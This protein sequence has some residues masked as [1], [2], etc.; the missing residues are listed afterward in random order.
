MPTPSVFLAIYLFGGLTFVPLLLGAILVHAYFTF[1]VIEAAS[2]N[3]TTG[4]FNSPPDV[5]KPSTSNS[6]LESLPDELKPRVHEPDVAAGYFAVCRE[7]VPGG[8]NGKPPE[9]TTAVGGI[10][11]AES[12]SVYQSMYRSIFDRNKTSTPTLD[13]TNGRKKA[14]NLFYVVLR[15]GHLMLYDDSEQL[16]VRHVVSLALYEVDIYSGGEIIPEGELWIKRNCIRLIPNNTAGHTE[17]S[18]KPFFFFSD[19]CSEKEDFYFAILQ[20]QERASS[21]SKIP[22]TPLHFD[23]A[24]LVKLV[25]Q[26]HASEEN[27]QTRWINALVGRLFLGLYKTAEME[28]LI[29]KKITKKIARV[30]KPAFIDDIKLQKIDMGDLPPFIT[31]PKLRELTVDGG[32]T[33]EANVKYKGNFRIDI[34]AVARIDLGPRFKARE[35][36]LVLATILRKLEGHIL[37]RIKPPPSNRLWISFESAPKMDISLE[38]I[39][40]SR[41]ITYGVIL[42]AIESRIRE[43]VNETLVLPFWDDM[44][45][46][47]TASQRFRGGIWADDIVDNTLNTAGTTVTEPTDCHSENVDLDGASAEAP[48]MSRTNSGEVSRRIGDSTPPMVPA[49]RPRAMR[50]SSFASVASP[51]VDMSSTSAE[52]VK[53]QSGAN[54]QDAAATMKSIS[55]SQ[56]ASPVESPVGSPTQASRFTSLESDSNTTS[57]F[58]SSNNGTG[59]DDPERLLARSASVWTTT[60]KSSN[61]PDTESRSSDLLSK[62]ISSPLP[63]L[64]SAEKRQ[65]LNHSLNSATAAAKKWFVSRQHHASSSPSTSESVDPEQHVVGSRHTVSGGIQGPK[66]FLGSGSPQIPLSSQI[67]SEAF[68]PPLGSPS[69]PIGR[70]QPLPPPGTPLPLPPKPEKR[71]SAWGAASASA[72]ANLTRRKPFTMKQSNRTESAST[73]ELT[74]S[75]TYQSN[76]SSLLNNEPIGSKDKL[77]TPTQRISSS[78]N[79]RPIPPLPLRRKRLSFTGTDDITRTEE[80]LLIVEAPLPDG[81]VPSSP[82]DEVASI[83]VESEGNLRECRNQHEYYE[84]LGSE[85]DHSGVFGGI[86]MD[87]RAT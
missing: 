64:G 37:L 45:W 12:P 41:Q 30:P 48:P 6:E 61:S 80:G 62:H 63:V 70:G 16:E 23:T 43:V 27:L 84:N 79:S 49:N 85:G 47:N 22:P 14:R 32:L 59:N 56:S 25:Q 24:H 73:P 2:C 69:H 58:L 82:M 40:S 75:S 71:T 4:D 7:Y 46:T 67:T 83:E 17:A 21:S 39:V 8:V 44:P 18:A 11:A 66:E 72:L 81:N 76:P 55:K 54:Q 15:H 87:D 9:R 36:T 26:L 77:I 78:A 53:R 52:T 35:V 50:S 1:P 3:D 34:S 68:T 51:I 19:N 60:T 5:L 31:N 13:G 29:R 10:I 42:R 57:D 28:E 65:A 33:I 38:P 86:E 20:N 74:P